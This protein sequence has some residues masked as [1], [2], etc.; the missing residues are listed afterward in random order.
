MLLVYLFR[1]FMDYWTAFVGGTFL[2]NKQHGEVSIWAVGAEPR[3]K[4]VYMKILR[5][6]LK[7]E[8]IK[9]G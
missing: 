2:I 7:V 5:Q 8:I 1:R 3:G 6:L 4:R 9:E